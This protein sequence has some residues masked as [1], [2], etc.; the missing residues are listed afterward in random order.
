MQYTE[1]SRDLLLMAIC[2]SC[3][4]GAIKNDII[5]EEIDALTSFF[6]QTEHP[7][8]NRILY[9]NL[10]FLNPNSISPLTL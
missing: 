5:S 6:R 3:R 10:Y 4:G 8:I 9:A 1:L 7:V 2:L